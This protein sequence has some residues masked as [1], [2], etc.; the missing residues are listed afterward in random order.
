MGKLEGLVV[1]PCL[2]ARGGEL[3]FEVGAYFI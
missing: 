3:P 2:V 1:L